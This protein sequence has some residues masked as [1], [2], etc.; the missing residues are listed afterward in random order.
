[1]IGAVGAFAS[2]GGPQLGASKVSSGDL[3]NF[4]ISSSILKQEIDESHQHLLEEWKDS[5]RAQAG[6]APDWSRPG[7]FGLRGLAHRVER[8]G[9]SFSVA[10]QRPHGVRLIAEIPLMA[11]T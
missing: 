5:L 11:Q 7:H 2:A 1:M 3:Y 10:N 8:L 6:L 9:G 4:G